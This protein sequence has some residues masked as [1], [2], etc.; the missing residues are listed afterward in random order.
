MAI[1]ENDEIVGYRLIEDVFTPDNSE[2]PE[3]EFFL[4]SLGPPINEVRLV[5][6]LSR[7]D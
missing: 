4:I 7:I 5:A 2:S 3:M 6:E 1:D